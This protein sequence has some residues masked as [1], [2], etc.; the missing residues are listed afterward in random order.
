MPSAAPVTTRTQIPL[1]ILPL[2]DYEFAYANKHY[3]FETNFEKVYAV[4][5]DGTRVTLCDEH[6]RLMKITA[7][8]SVGIYKCGLTPFESYVRVELLMVNGELVF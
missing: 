1:Y 4:R 2:P 3:Y 8:V 5:D 7:A 6:A